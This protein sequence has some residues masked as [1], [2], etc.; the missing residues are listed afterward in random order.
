HAATSSTYRRVRRS[1]SAEQRAQCGG[2]RDTAMVDAGWRET[3]ACARLLRAT[4]VLF[5]CPAS[6]RATAENAAAMRSF[7]ARIGR[8]AGLL[9][10][11]EPRGPWPD[12]LVRELCEE[13]ELVHVVD[14]M[15]RPTVTRG[16]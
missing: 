3:L 14:P 7:F 6:F 10:L 1:L 15:Q 5:Q 8:T 16:T 9:H 11:W 4:A 13:L 12:A 2:F